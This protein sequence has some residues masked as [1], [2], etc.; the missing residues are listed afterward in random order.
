M[1]NHT[2]MMIHGV[3]E[4]S[5]EPQKMLKDC[6]EKDICKCVTIH[7]RMDD[8]STTIISLFTTGSDRNISMTTKES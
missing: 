8:G 4:V 7:V 1:A 6:S 2:T 5:I 3:E